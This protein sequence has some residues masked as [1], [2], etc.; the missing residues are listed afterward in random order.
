MQNLHAKK[1]SVCQRVRGR[2]SGQH[3]CHTVALTRGSVLVVAW[4]SKQLPRP[5]GF[6]IIAP[7]LLLFEPR[8]LLQLHSH[9]MDGTT[10]WSA[11]TMDFL[12]CADPSS[13]A[14]PISC[15]FDV[16]TA[17]GPLEHEAG[18]SD[19]ASTPLGHGSSADQMLVPIAYPLVL[20]DPR[21]YTRVYP[22]QPTPSLAGLVT[23]LF[24][25]IDDPNGRGE[26]AALVQEIL[27][28]R[29]VLV[30]HEHL[31]EET[32]L[33][34]VSS[35]AND[36]F[37]LIHQK[38]GVETPEITLN[39][40]KSGYL[41][42]GDEQSYPGF[43]MLKVQGVDSRAHDESISVFAWRTRYPESI[44]CGRHACRTL[45]PATLG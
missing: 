21:D 14:I 34:R 8:C 44:A 17:D 41:Y 26:T 25:Q 12:A 3:T 11:G 22:I 24:R 29:A 4:V 18:S 10:S 27:N 7:R 36:A 13:V 42:A 23:E 16:E 31:R 32:T 9:A 39:G 35:E 38:R 43:A 45:A 37:F 5:F 6:C 15:T 33:N 30:E 19:I 20:N 1:L 28:S 2:V 40:P